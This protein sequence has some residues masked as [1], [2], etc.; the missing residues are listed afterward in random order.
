MVAPPYHSSPSLA[1]FMEWSVSVDVDITTD[2]DMAVTPA[3]NVI[4]V[5]TRRSRS[6]RCL[7]SNSFSIFLTRLV[8]IA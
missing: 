7:F 2:R 5:A 4:C 8:A 1:V 6:G 3:S